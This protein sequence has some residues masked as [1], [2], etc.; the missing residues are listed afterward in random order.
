M[1][2]R[3]KLFKGTEE[4]KR[5]VIASYAEIYHMKNGGVVA[6]DGTEELDMALIGL[7]TCV[8]LKRKRQR[9]AERNSNGGGGGGDGGG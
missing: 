9:N 5:K 4:T 8:M 6:I 7:L 1:S 3:F 2:R